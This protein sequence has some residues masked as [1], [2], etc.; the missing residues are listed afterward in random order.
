MLTVRE[1]GTWMKIKYQWLW[2]SCTCMNTVLWCTYPIPKISLK[3]HFSHPLLRP[4][5]D[6]FMS[7]DQFCEEENQR[8]AQAT[9][10]S[11]T[12]LLSLSLE[13]PL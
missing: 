13:K 11:I 5:H 8:E 3:P 7:F 2:G 9:R 12:R 1:R 6:T 4:L 10:A